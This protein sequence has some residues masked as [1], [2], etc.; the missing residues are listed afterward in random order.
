M[1]QSHEFRCEQQKDQTQ[2]QQRST[3][4]SRPK[5][6]VCRTRIRSSHDI[7]WVSFPNSTN[8]TEPIP[9]SRLLTIHWFSNQVLIPQ[10]YHRDHWVYRSLPILCVPMILRNTCISKDKSED[11]LSKSVNN[12]RN[13]FW[14]R[15]HFS[16]SKLKLLINFWKNVYF[17]RHRLLKWLNNN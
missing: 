16:N 9:D 5:L 2:V 10:L 1:G 6:E 13:N 14:K 3:P 12:F 7:V 11:I 17:I 8:Q 15:L 4:D